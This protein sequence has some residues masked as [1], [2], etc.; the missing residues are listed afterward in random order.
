MRYVIFKNSE[1]FDSK[2]I[3]DVKDVKRKM[4]NTEVS[5]VISFAKVYVKV[6][7]GKLIQE[8]IM[9]SGDEE[10]VLYNYLNMREFNG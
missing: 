5:E 3:W 4:P 1:Y 10:Q 7:N 2:K 6:D 8:G 9:I